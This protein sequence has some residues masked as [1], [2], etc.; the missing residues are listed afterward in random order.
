MVTAEHVGRRQLIEQTDSTRGN[1]PETHRTVF[2]PE[3]H[4]HDSQVNMKSMRPFLLSVLRKSYPK[5]KNVYVHR[6]KKGPQHEHVLY[7]K[8]FIRPTR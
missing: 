4:T 7:S 2:M 1:V 8:L 3:T 5:P 6:N